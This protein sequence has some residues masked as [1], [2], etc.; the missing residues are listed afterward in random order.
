MRRE[1]RREL[2]RVDPHLGVL[3]LLVRIADA[4]EVLDD[5]RARLRVEALAIAPL[6]NLERRRDVDLEEAAERLDHLAHLPA[7]RRIRRD[8]RADR[9][10]A[11]LRDLA[12]DE[13]DA[14]DVE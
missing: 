6:A 5:A 4:R 11:V 12:R 9:D 7:R 3:G 13:A 2:R 1:I 14:E 10:T 8:R